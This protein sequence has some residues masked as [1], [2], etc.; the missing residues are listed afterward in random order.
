MKFA[1]L[2]T[3]LIALPLALGATVRWD[4]T[5]GNPSGSMSSVS[6][7]DGANGLASRFPTF[8]KVPSFPHVGAV[9][10]ASWNSPLCGSCWELKY[11]G[12][13][14]YITAVD[15]AR[16]A[17]SYIISKKAMNDLTGGQAVPLGTAQVSAKKVS[18][19]KCH[20]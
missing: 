9:P 14:I 12:K 3:S 2:I 11:K 5:Y 7:S 17:D 10:G 8:G 19:S 13:A 20:L 18:N 6:C 15:Q 16:N 1:A 4:D